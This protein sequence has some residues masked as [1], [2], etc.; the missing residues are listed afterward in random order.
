MPAAA[1]SWAENYV[2]KL[3]SPAALYDR[4]GVVLAANAAFLAGVGRPDFTPGHTKIDAL[5]GR[6]TGRDRWDTE[7]NPGRRRCYRLLGAPGLDRRIE[8]SVELLSEQ[9]TA[10]QPDDLRVIR[11]LGAAASPDNERG[12]AVSELG[13]SLAL[14]GGADG[15]W[16]WNPLTKDL[17]LS[18]RLLAI[19]GYPDSFEVR[20][21][22]DWLDLVHPDDRVRYNRENIRHLRR[23]TPY[24]QC[25]YRLRRA[26]GEWAWGYSR[27]LASFD[28]QG[29]ARRMAG[30]ITDISARKAAEA[31]LDA[32]R[33]ALESLNASLESRVAERTRELALALDELR[34]THHTLD[35]AHEQLVQAETLASLGRMVA[36]IAHEL[37]TPI[38]NSR[39]AATT[40]RE[41]AKFF[42]EQARDGLRRSELE[43][44]LSMLDV[45]TQLLDESLHRAASLVSGFKQL[46]VDQTSAQRRPFT[47]DNVLGEI[48]V[49]LGPSLRRSGCRVEWA[50]EEGIELDSY[51]GA[52]SQVIINLIENA[53][54]HAFDGQAPGLIE[55]SAA[56]TAAGQVAITVR[57]DGAGIPP[58]L[59]RKVF[60][61][62]FTTRIGR[63]GTGL[64]LNIVYN[65]TTGI[66]GGHIHLR[67]EP[68]AGSSFEL[69]LPR[70]APVA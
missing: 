70:H 66:L 60:E 51:P 3:E 31:A 61:P 4:A 17:Y 1:P 36:V 9:L 29:V 43:S 42:A 14:Q 19:L 28:E 49:T 69:V 12:L 41:R 54:V 47:L 11:L 63:G 40:L 34:R 38:G 6:T 67:S 13:Y 65:L 52:L 16:E 45:G 56:A 59:Q 53:T 15:M 37:N 23:E 21:T 10:D 44:F 33:Q 26:D 27:G 57:D 25:E 32:T 5:L 48:R 64:G 24:F 20:T 55:V 46:A 2:A 22:D 7:F 50:V 62:F 39:I 68:G 8:A 30:S 35:Q 58:S 18:P